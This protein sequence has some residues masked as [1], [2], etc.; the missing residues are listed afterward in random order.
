MALLRVMARP[1]CKTLPAHVASTARAIKP[2]FAEPNVR[3]R[4][5]A[6]VN[7]WSPVRR[8]VVIS[9]TWSLAQASLKNLIK[10]RRHGNQEQTEAE[11]SGERGPDDGLGHGVFCA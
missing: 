9:L 10:E 4:S 1:P 11:S 7:Y 3:F 8:H 6:G 2:V 5:Q